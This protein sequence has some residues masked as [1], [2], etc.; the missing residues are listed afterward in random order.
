MS[1]ALRI[2][3]TGGSGRIGRRLVALLA[4]H[5]HRVVSIDQRPFLGAPGRFV[6]ADLRDRSLLH[7]VFAEVDAVAHLG[8]IPNVDVPVSP[9]SV[10]HHNTAVGSAVMQTAAD[11]GVKRLVYASSCQAYGLWGQQRI[12]PR[13]WPMDETHP[14]LPQNAYGLGKAMNEEYARLVARLHGISVAIFRFPWVLDKRPDFTLAEDRAWLEGQ[15]G[16][17]EAVGIHVHLDDLAEAFRLA[18]EQPRPGCEAYHF[19]SDDVLTALHVRER[20]RQHEP[21]YPPLPADWPFARSP[22]I[23]AKAREHFGW[24]PRWNLV[25]LYRSAVGRDPVAG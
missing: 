15:T 3:V 10:F 18:L 1:G 25:S 9:D 21:G 6:F 14:L 12:A 20:Q 24:R 11:L 22:M 16:P 5:G 4:E 8:E 13:Q 2:A 23:T 19:G 7:G 17:C